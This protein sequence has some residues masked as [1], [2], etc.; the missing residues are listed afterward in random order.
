MTKPHPP[1]FI[2]N[3]RLNAVEHAQ[4][5]LHDCVRCYFAFKKMCWS[6]H[7]DINITHRIESL[8]FKIIARW[9]PALEN[10][11]QAAQ[12]NGQMAKCVVA[13]ARLNRRTIYQRY[14]S[15]MQDLADR[16]AEELIQP[17]NIENTICRTFGFEE[18]PRWDSP[19]N[20]QCI[21]AV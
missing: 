17:A 4:A 14:A 5:K 9:E 7:L 20:I 12:A 13:A 11:E 21:N 2:T 10:I 3:V 18:G 19:G 1:T 8:M 6:S 15:H 16:M